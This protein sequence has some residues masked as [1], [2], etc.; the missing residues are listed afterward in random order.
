MMKTMGALS[1][2]VLRI[3]PLAIALVA[4]ARVDAQET[5]PA[6]QDLGQSQASVPDDSNALGDIVVTAQKREQALN[7]VPM[8]I[9]ALSGDQLARA[10]VSDTRD[11]VK[12]VPGFNYTESAFGTPVYTLRGVGFYETSLGAKP[13]V[14]VYVDEVPLPFSVLTRGATLDLQ[15][16]EVLKGPQGTLFGQNATGGAINYIAAKP[17]SSFEAGVDGSYG[18]FN[19]ID[20]GGFISGPLSDTLSARL[21]AKTEQGGAW[22]RSYTRDDKLGDR[23]FTTARLLFDFRPSDTLR[24]ELNLNGFLDKS[25]EVAAQLLQV[26]PFTPAVAPLVPPELYAYPVAPHGNRAADWTPAVDPRRNHRFLQAALRSEVDLTDDLKVTS[27]TAYSDYR[28]RQS[29]DPDG[30]S[31]RN[32]SYRTTG[33]ITSFSQELRVEGKI[34]DNLT[35]IVGANYNRE[36][37]FQRDNEGPYDQSGPAF[38]LT[39]FPGVP[40]Y[41]TY[42]QQAK[43]KFRTAAAFANLDFDVT[44]TITLHAGARYTDARIGFNG[45]TYDDGTADGAGL[46]LGIQALANLIRGSVGLP[47]IVVPVGGCIVLDGNTLAPVDPVRN[48]LNQKNVSWRGGVDYKPNDSTLMYFN[49]SRGY[50][51]GSFPLLSATDVNQFNPV[52]QESVTAYELGGKVSLFDRKAQVNAAVFYYDYRNKQLKGRVV[53]TPNVFGPL[54]ALINVP[55]SSI[56]GAEI[57]ILL[58]PARGVRINLG[59]TYIDSK[60]KGDFLNITSYGDAGNFGGEPFPYTPKYQLSSDFEYRWSVGQGL[61]AWLG[62]NVAY[63][64]KTN[65]AFGRLPV[66][67]IDAYT[68]VDFR[69]GISSEQAKW[70]ATA[71]LRNAFDEYYWSNAT[72]VLDTT[73]RYAGRPRTFG[74]SLSYRY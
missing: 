52:S 70:S 29:I 63:Q 21:S 61:E 73:V 60:I 7:D 58:A 30:V 64:G 65:A 31:L 5:V 41:F 56:K 23:N 16:V 68:L 54:E 11:L 1:L 13:T 43:Q 12:L 72:K 15:R 69:A 49:V 32:Y 57:Q 53:A 34:T 17:T 74:L 9:S 24:F 4:A 22:Q 59:G 10:G 18:R 42:Y 20:L 38:Q 36:N 71:F 14:S 50:K 40:P 44:S 28:H 19:A 66:L 47:S 39:A 62:A 51:S 67:A 45:C 25:D 2:N 6:S 48:R 33:D 37:V 46:R 3:S 26:I 27:I 55:K 35:V 8:S